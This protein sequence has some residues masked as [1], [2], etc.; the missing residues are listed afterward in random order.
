[1]LNYQR[2]SWFISWFIYILW[3]IG[4]D[5]CRIPAFYLNIACACS[6]C[7]KALP[8]IGYD[9]GG[10]QAWQDRNN[11]SECGT[12]WFLPTSQC[13]VLL[14]CGYQA[15]FSDFRVFTIS[16]LLCL[17]ASDVGLSIWQSP[18]WEFRKLP[19]SVEKIVK[20][21]IERLWQPSGLIFDILHSRDAVRLH[22]TLALGLWAALIECVLSILECT[23]AYCTR[24]FN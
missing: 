20:L 11:P 21:D 14:F 12:T 23:A 2:V 10:K 9:S 17:K 18:T 1:M 8:Y 16:S 22:R 13:P 4:W 24:V 19:S 3:R 7:A 5:C 6:S 15:N